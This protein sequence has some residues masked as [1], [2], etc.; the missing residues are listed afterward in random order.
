[1]AAIRRYSW[2]VGHSTTVAIECGRTPCV[3]QFAYNDIFPTFNCSLS[4][5]FGEC[6]LHQQC[7]DEAKKHDIE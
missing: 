5:D 6:T 1:M 3:A 2:R 7:V 4:S